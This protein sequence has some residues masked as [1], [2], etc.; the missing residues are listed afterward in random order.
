[1]ILT[2]KLIEIRNMLKT[3]DHDDTLQLP[4]IVVIG[5]QSSGKS[6]VL[7]A[8]VGREF[9]PKG[10]NMVTRRPIELTLVNTPDSKEEYA[11]FPQLGLEKVQDF[12]QVQKTLVD[13]NLSVSDAECVSTNPIELRI[14]SPN[15]PDLTLIDLPGYIQ[16]HNVNQPPALKQKIQELC[17]YY[18]RRQNIILAVSAADVDLANSEA[19]LASRRVDPLG[20]RTIGVITK[21][22]LVT[23]ESGISILRN[24]DYPLHLGYIGVICKNVSGESEPS[25][26]KQVVRAEEQYFRSNPVYSQRNIVVGTANLREKLTHVLEENMR[27]NLSTIVDRVQTELEEARY[28]FKVE[29]NDRRVTAESYVAETMDTL[30][31]KF[32]DFASTFGKPQVRQELRNLL[33]ERVLDICAEMYWSD[34]KIFS[35]GKEKLDEV[36]WEHKLDIC[37]SLLTK[38]GLGRSS[39]QMVVDLVMK[40]MEKLAS[41]EPFLHHPDTQRQIVQFSHEILKSKYQVTVDQVE[42]TIKPYKYEVEC[43]EQEWADGL[44]RSIGL[45][46]KE[47][48]M[49]EYA[50]TNIKTTVGK[51]KLRS[52]IKHVLDSERDEQRRTASKAAIVHDDQHADVDSELLDA[53]KPHFNPI[54]LEK[55]K[56]A[57]CLKQRAMI[58]KYRLA[59]LKSRKCRSV[60]NKNMCPEVFLNVVAE[61]LVYTAVMFIQVE[62]LNEFFFL[63]PREVDNRLYYGL[64]R[65]EIDYF[66][67]ENPRVMKQLKLAERKKKLE[68]VMEK[69]MYLVRRQ[70]EFGAIQYRR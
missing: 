66:A 48:S 36:Y 3:I 6:S 26:N 8:I 50:L 56:E 5:S 45:L 15:I 35:L 23:P 14:Y 65:N 59:T 19:L 7:E 33:E 67:K 24:T 61:K 18:I 46:Q 1:M 69:L 63:F 49:C 51:A 10:S 43:T 62:L 54:L 57:I 53:A 38:S 11:E 39:T 55:A 34:P 2:K 29:Y 42:N 30:K 37:S 70:E 13:L 22:D 47:I 20:V 4:S 60:D 16:I 40:N 17:E 64:N 12:K 44:K 21:M 27:R 52:A 68:E 25:G 9:L 41:N 31:L 58:L 28:Q 32:K